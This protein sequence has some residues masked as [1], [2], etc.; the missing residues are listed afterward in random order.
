MSHGT[1]VRLALFSSVCMAL[2]GC[3]ETGDAYIA[4]INPNP[5]PPAD[6]PGE[7]LDPDEV[8]SAQRIAA[9]I[10]A[11]LAR[12]YPTGQI[13]RDAHPKSTGCVDAVFTVNNDLDAKFRHGIFAEPGRSYRAVIRFSN[14][15]ENPTLPDR[16]PDGRGMAIKL[17][18]LGPNQ[19]PIVADPLSS[20][21]PRADIPFVAPDYM[22][23]AG[24]PS[25]DFVMISHPVFLV[26]DPVGYRKVIGNTDSA[27]PLAAIVRPFIALEGLGV[28]GIRN[29]MAI[30]SLKIANPLAQR[31]WSMVPYRLGTGPTAIATKFSVLPVRFPADTAAPDPTDPDFLRHAMARSLDKGEAKFA[32]AIQP[33][34]AP[35]QPVEDPR[36]DWPETEA[37][38]HTVATITVPKQNFDTVPRNTACEL[39]S[40]SPWHALPDHRPLGAVNRMR[41]VI[42]QYISA[43]RRDKETGAAR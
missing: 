2:G 25:Q 16:D 36:I 35:S 31:Y 37:P 22:Q 5:Y 17:F 29:A 26:A 3:S 21:T 11:H 34:T 15:N 40:Y 43:F 32:F 33:R 27:S 24:G 14:S 7:V 8:Q 30:T 23:L 18:D 39:L 9:I 10:E 38:F 4:S 42:Y 19:V 28:T 6:G 20:L 41:K 13:R 1:V 12:L